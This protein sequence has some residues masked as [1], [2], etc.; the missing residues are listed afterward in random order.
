MITG[1]EITATR[2]PSPA[3]RDVQAARGGDFVFISGS[4]GPT[5]PVTGTSRPGTVGEETALTLS[6]LAEIAT[7]AGGLLRAAVKVTVYLA[8]IEDFAD[9]DEVYGD[10]FASDPPA[11]TTVA[12]G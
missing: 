4:I 3:G 9:F 5:D 10:F 11:R 6:N 2:A 12:A 1:R 8:R 7:A